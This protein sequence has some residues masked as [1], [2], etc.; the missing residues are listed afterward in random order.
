MNFRVVIILLLTIITGSTWGCSGN[1]TS[2]GV[3][4][5][6][7]MCRPVPAAKAPDIVL[8]PDFSQQELAEAVLAA[9]GGCQCNS[10]CPTELIRDNE[11]GSYTITCINECGTATAT[12][13]IDYS[14]WL[15]SWDQALARAQQEN[16]IIMINFYTDMCPACKKLDRDTFAHEQV[17][18]EMCRSFISLKSYAGKGNLYMKY[19]ISGVPITVFALPDGREL[20]R[21]IGYVPPQDFLKG[22]TEVMDMWEQV[23]QSGQLP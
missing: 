16:K 11:D 21:I 19:G 3:Q 23:Q 17:A 13:D 4:I 20:G 12:G 8:C 10:P 9:G 18:T 15:S 1:G 5:I 2:D 22:F 14:Q 7:D 6:D